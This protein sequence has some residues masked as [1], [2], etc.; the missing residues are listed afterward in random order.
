MKFIRDL[1]I[2]TIVVVGVITIVGYKYFSGET[3]LE[4]ANNLCSLF[5]GTGN[6]VSKEVVERFDPTQAHYA[7]GA[8]AFLG[9]LCF[10]GISHLNGAVNWSWGYDQTQLFNHS[11]YQYQLKLKNAQKHD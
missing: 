1:S 5:Y 3:K 8:G 2:G 11:E 9:R 7:E 4:K 10:F 6:Y